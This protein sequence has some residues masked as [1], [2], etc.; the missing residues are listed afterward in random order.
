MMYDIVILYIDIPGHYVSQLILWHQ[1]KIEGFIVR[2]WLKEWPEC[3]KQ[4]HQWISEVH[5]FPVTNLAHCNLILYGY[6]LA[7]CNLILY[8]Y[9]HHTPK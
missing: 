8:G 5:T 6:N 1:L 7:H 3:F 2:R 4:M 9:N